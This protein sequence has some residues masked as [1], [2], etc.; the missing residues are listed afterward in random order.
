MDGSNFGRPLT[1]NSLMQGLRDILFLLLIAITAL[2]VASPVFAQTTTGTLRGQVLDAS[3][4]AVPVAQVSVTNQRTSVVVNV[5]TTSA[6][7]YNI[8]ST[9]PGLYTVAVQAKGFRSATKKDVTVVA[10]QDNVADFS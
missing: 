2:G 7:T 5:T 1:G 9:I 6:G 8:P 10:N 4:A 3:H